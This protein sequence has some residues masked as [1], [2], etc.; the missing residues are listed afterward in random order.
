MPKKV[1]PTPR[2]YD[3]FVRMLLSWSFELT[4]RETPTRNGVPVRLI[5]P[6][7]PRER[8]EGLKFTANGLTV[9]VWTTWIKALNKARDEDAAWV[10]ITNS[11][12]KVL[13][14]GRPIHR[15]KNFFK[16]LGKRAW[17]ARW[18]VKNRPLCTECDV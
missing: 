12:G 10:I 6:R 14:Y 16:T 7:G 8:E 5:S 18:R 3:R 1:R 17:I 4:S 9:Y 15:T 2:A 13:Y 11:R